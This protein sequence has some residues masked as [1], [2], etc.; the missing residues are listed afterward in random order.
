MDGYSHVLPASLSVNF[1]ELLGI[2]AFVLLYLYY[3]IQ[4][5][6]TYRFLAPV[7]FSY[8]LHVTSLK[9]RIRL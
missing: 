9:F 7:G 4:A 5:P 2:S 6:G 3:D 1:L 8:P